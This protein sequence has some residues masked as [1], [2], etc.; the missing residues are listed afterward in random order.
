[1]LITLQNIVWDEED[2]RAG[3]PSEVSVN[4]AFA[5]GHILTDGDLADLMDDVSIKHECAIDSC[6][7]VCH[8][9]D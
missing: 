2:A 3:L 8:D 5:N 1:M 6:E 4:T 9:S 7:F